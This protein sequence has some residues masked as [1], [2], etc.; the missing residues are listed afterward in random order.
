M[1]APA[2]EGGLAWPGPSDSPLPPSPSL[3]PRYAYVTMVTSDD[4]VIGAQLLCHSLRQH[5]C[6]FPLLALVTPNLK[7]SSLHSL[8]TSCI[9]PVLVSP[10]PSPFPSHVPSWS[11]PGLT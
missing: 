5:S 2:E 10:L 3:P 7:A 1:A 8:S 6:T 9:H 11:S 4:F